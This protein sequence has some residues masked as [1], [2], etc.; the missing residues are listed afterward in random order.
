[1][2]FDG[3]IYSVVRIIRRFNLLIDL[4]YF[5]PL[6]SKLLNHRYMKSTNRTTFDPWMR[7]FFW[8]RHFYVRSTFSWLAYERWGQIC[9]SRLQHQSIITTATTTLSSSANRQGKMADKDAELLLKHIC[10][11]RENAFNKA[12]SCLCLLSCK[13]LQGL[14]PYSDVWWH[15]H[16]AKLISFSLM[17]LLTR[18]ARVA[19]SSC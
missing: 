3:W 18:K 13:S 7:F 16:I 1:M 2:N 19:P 15:T 10:E 11:S 5:F 9:T 14:F 8:C 17:M 4:W 6:V 12:G